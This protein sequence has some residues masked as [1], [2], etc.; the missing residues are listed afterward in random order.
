MGGKGSSRAIAVVGLLVVMALAAALRLPGLDRVKGQYWD[1]SFY[2]ADAAAYL[3]RAQ[4]ALRADRPRPS[5]A[6]NSWMQP[7]LGKWM[8]AAGEL[9]AG[10]HEWG[11]RLPAALFGIA[12]VGL[13]YLI[14]LELW[15]SPA[16]AGFAGA[17]LSLDGLHLVQSRI[18]MLDIFASTFAL[19][20]LY[21]VVRLAVLRPPVL[22]PPV[23]RPPV[24]RL[25]VPAWTQPGPGARSRGLMW[26]Y[27]V[28]G[29]ALGAAVACKW[30]ALP[31]LA[32]AGVVA[33]MWGPRSEST[34]RFSRI[35]TFAIAFAALPLAVYVLS[36]SSFF[37]EHGLDVWGWLRLQAAMLRYGSHFHP[38]GGWSSTAWQ[39]PLSRRPIDYTAVVYFPGVRLVHGRV[40]VLRVITTGN[41]VLWWGFLAAAPAVLWRWLRRRSRADG[42]IAC[43]YLAGWAPWL[44]PGRTEFIYYL[45]PAVPFMAL[46][47]AGAARSAGRVAQGR[48]APVAPAIA[49]AVA[50]GAVAATVRYYPLWTAL[51][52]SPRAFSA[53]L[54]LPGV[55]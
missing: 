17:L 21:A 5:V 31:Y 37:V 22:R 12:G 14:A 36:Y 2:A 10:N 30:S 8:I 39:W 35:R 38:V 46:A 49:G 3:G 24:L 43:G 40:A 9:V 50:A 32:L 20:G 13:T 45:L 54:H 47:V 4:P 15:K 28:A 42:L 16:W 29:L 53:L 6:E 26:R 33:W 51:P 48:A 44:L 52:I 7:P 41:P 1:E 27:C 11:W 25:S 19:A 23:L 55:V 34:S 18:A